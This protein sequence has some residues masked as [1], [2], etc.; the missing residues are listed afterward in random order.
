M[1]ERHHKRYFAEALERRAYLDHSLVGTPGNDTIIVATTGNDATGHTVHVT[2]NNNTTQFDDDGAPV[3][4]DA[5]DGNDH[6]E[7]RTVDD[8]DITILAGHGDDTCIVG[9]GN[10]TD[11]IDGS[12][13]FG[14][15]AL[16]NGGNDS[17]V[18]DDSFGTDVN[19]DGHTY[20]VTDEH[21]DVEETIGSCRVEWDP[22]IESKLLKATD[23][24]DLFNIA[25]IDAG[26]TIN[27]SDGNDFFQLGTDDHTVQNGFVV[28]L[29]G[30]TDVPTAATLDAGQGTGDFLLIDD[31]SSLSNRSTIDVSHDRVLDNLSAI[32]FVT[33][34]I[35]T[36][37][38]TPAE[39][40][41]FT[42]LGAPTNRVTV[43]GNTGDDFISLGTAA[44]PINVSSYGMTGQ[45]NLGNGNN[46]IE[47]HDRERVPSDPPDKFGFSYPVVSAIGTVFPSRRLTSSSSTTWN[48]FCDDA[49]NE[50]DMA[51]A[52]GP[53]GTQWHVHING[54][55]GNDFVQPVDQ[56]QDGLDPAL[57]A[58]NQ[59]AFIDFTYGPDFSFDG[60]GGQ[61]QLQLFSEV[62]DND[63]HSQYFIGPNSLLR[64]PAGQ[65]LTPVIA[66][67]SNV[68][69]LQFIGDGDP[70]VIRFGDL[71]SGGIEYIRIDGG[72][73]G[74]DTFTNLPVNGGPRVLGNDL[75]GITEIVSNFA[76][77]NT[78]TLNDSAD[79]AATYKMDTIGTLP[80][81]T[82]TSSLHPTPASVHWESM[83]L[84]QLA[85]SAFSDTMTISKIDPSATDSI[86]GGSGNDAFIVGG[87]DL[88]SNG[89]DHLQLDGG[90]GTNSIEFDDHLDTF[91]TS[92]TEDYNLNANE[93]D[94]GAVTVDYTNFASQTLDAS[95]VGNG[96]PSSDETVNLNTT[97][98]P[99]TIVGCFGRFCVI[100]VGFTD[101]SPI[102]APVTLTMGGI[103]GAVI[104][105]QN[106][107]G[108]KSYTITSST[109][110]ASSGQ[111]INFSGS[112]ITLNANAGNNA[113]NLLSAGSNEPMVIHGNGGNDTITVGSGNLQQDFAVVPAIID[114]GAGTDS[115]VFD[116]SHDPVADPTTLSGTGLTVGTVTFP[117]STVEA[118]TVNTGSA[119][120]TFT[121]N[122]I[123]FA[124]TV[125]GGSGND[126]IVISKVISS[127]IVDGG[128][129]NDTIRIGSGNLDTDLLANVVARGGTSGNDTIVL[130]D[131]ADTGDDTYNLPSTNIFRKGTT[132]H[133]VSMSNFDLG[134]LS[135]NV[136]NDTINVATG[137][138][139]DILGNDG[140]DLLDVE[141][142]SGTFPPRPDV[143][144]D[145][146]RGL[147]IVRDNINGIGTATVHFFNRQDLATLQIGTGGTA[148][149]DA[150]NG[151]L[152]DTQVLTFSP[153]AARLDLNDNDLIID[154][155]GA[156]PQATIRSL[157]NAGRHNGAWDGTVGITS[158]TARSNPNHH[159]TLGML[160]AVE[161]RGIYGTLANF[162]NQTIDNSSLLIKYTYY[163]DT[164]FN[165]KVNFDDY[166]RTDNGFN[167]HRSGWLNGD[168]DL[169]G[170]VNF[171]DYV[172]IDLAFNTQ[173]S[174]L[175]RDM[176]S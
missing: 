115:V 158:S 105:D 114:G 154:Y 32:N 126:S 147:D 139:L 90:P 168:F 4:I 60:G 87:G 65:P 148:V 121:S 152:I 55:G 39:Q 116:N 93:L 66:T 46:T 50:I 67:Y 111:V 159:T 19:G 138:P 13:T 175:G 28:P 24:P 174:A 96:L 103:G 172:L 53:V 130:D 143:G 140:A 117:F 123:G 76:N 144:F 40:V 112:G 99:T 108:D 98:I 57:L 1:S 137:M 166:V 150:G 109:V 31:S 102:T 120:G 15:H 37:A 68:E 73:G 72:F 75:A 17:L 56:V 104:N 42:G 7:V 71:G 119:G 27:G 79:T 132:G 5:G 10:L 122:G 70:N 78:L 100:N 2:I 51:S 170:Q 128:D 89:F 85:Q 77:N 82:V 22:G 74:R 149:A 136:G 49:N 153:T 59:R 135:A 164:D 97:S 131:H 133:T 47:I 3:E 155:T 44:S 113:I 83:Q 6:I 26:M 157:I 41:I 165:G 91:N 146:G 101:L 11:D 163:G 12:V 81:L 176:R 134:V 33:M 84:F 38:M 58:E 29:Q 36:H 20:D 21:V 110:T 173:G 18:M 52:A 61:D 160:E 167:N 64:A 86:Y 35:N 145:G 54:G 161:F 129:G 69:D 171:D 124:L 63:L 62:A 23:G 169:N 88:D 30:P 14:N 43:S 107:T 125:Q 48:L 80:Q 141:G 142:S 45:F 8:E 151:A 94:K 118:L 106:S 34:R 16:D 162:D 127:V 25:D 92:E 156:S 9:T 95:T